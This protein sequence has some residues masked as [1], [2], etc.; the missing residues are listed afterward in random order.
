MGEPVS[1]AV[2]FAFIEHVVHAPDSRSE[3]AR[4]ISILTSGRT[5]L[6]SVGIEPPVFEDL[7]NIM[8]SIVQQIVTPD[9]NGEKMDPDVLLEAFQTTEGA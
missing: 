8:V 5:L 1:L 3:V 4:A 9:L 7:L 2:G 6:E